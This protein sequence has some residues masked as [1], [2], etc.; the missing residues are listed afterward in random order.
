[1]KRDSVASMGITVPYEYIQEYQALEDE[2]NKAPS[3]KYVDIY[4]KIQRLTT[5]ISTDLGSLEV[6]ESTQS[7][8]QVYQQLKTNYSEIYTSIYAKIVI[9]SVCVILIVRYI[10]Y[11]IW[12]MFGL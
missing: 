7:K 10:I 9:L 4:S 12:P 6:Y 2:F 3:S 11:Y 1:M 8:P 5:R